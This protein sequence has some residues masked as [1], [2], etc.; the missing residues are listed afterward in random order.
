MTRLL[1]AVDAISGILTAISLALLLVLVGDM[2]Y[3]VASRRL[4]SAPTLWAYD[5]AYMA[6]GAGF[7]FAAAYTLRHNG[8]IRIDFLSSRLP[9]RAQDGINFAAYLVLILPALAILVAGAYSAWLRAW[10]TGEVDP[11]SPWKPVMWPFYAAMTVGFAA[12]WLQATAEGVR[13]ARSAFGGGPS[14]LDHAPEDVP[15]A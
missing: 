1:A 9:R 15:E 14:P 11:A 5:I 10:L 13:H 12:L 7:V 8:H 2:I 3:E 6:N 4:F